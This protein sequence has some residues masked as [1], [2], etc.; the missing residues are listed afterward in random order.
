[1]TKNL[2]RVVVYDEGNSYMMPDDPLTMWSR[3]V[4]WQ[5]ESLISPIPQTL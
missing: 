3:E 1:M 4:T 5:I 2:G